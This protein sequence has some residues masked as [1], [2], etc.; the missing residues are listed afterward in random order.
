MLPVV[1]TAATT[2]ASGVDWATEAG[3]E[4]GRK[5]AREARSASP[6]PPTSLFGECARFVECTE[7]GEQLLLS[8]LLYSE[9]WSRPPLEEIRA[10]DVAQAWDSAMHLRALAEEAIARAHGLNGDLGR[11]DAH[12]RRAAIGFPRVY[13]HTEAFLDHCSLQG[14]GPLAAQD[15]SEHI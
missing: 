2:A 9:Q 7:G 3:R 12:A 10:H 5:A 14:Q 1:T 6:T 15:S 8:M 11:R 13:W 4:A